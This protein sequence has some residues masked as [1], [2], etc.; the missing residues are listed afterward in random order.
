M[1]QKCFSSDLIQFSLRRN[2]LLV[3]Q[4]NWEIFIE[5]KPLL[6]DKKEGKMLPFLRQPNYVNY[7][8][9]KFNN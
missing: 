3:K 2:M 4:N 9:V 6:R 8:I 7:M 5:L 1:V